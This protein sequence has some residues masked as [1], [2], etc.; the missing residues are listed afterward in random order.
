M[1]K[2]FIKSIIFWTCGLATLQ[3][4]NIDTEKWDIDHPFSA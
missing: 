1:I 3:H 2:F 4:I